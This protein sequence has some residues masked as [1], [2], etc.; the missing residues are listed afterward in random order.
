M[1]ITNSGTNFDQSEL[2]FVAVASYLGD[3]RGAYGQNVSIALRLTLSPGEVPSYV[4]SLRGDVI[5]EGR[6]FTTPLVVN[7][8]TTPNATVQEYVVSEKIKTGNWR[9]QLIKHGPKNKKCKK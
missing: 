4:S 9:N 8:Q 2:Y 3:K 7:L 5:L 1:R 6:Y